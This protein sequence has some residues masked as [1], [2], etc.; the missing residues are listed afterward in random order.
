MKPKH[1]SRLS[2]PRDEILELQGEGLRPQSLAQHSYVIYEGRQQREESCKHMVDKDIP[3]PSQGLWLCFPP[4]HAHSL[5]MEW[6][7]QDTASE[8]TGFSGVAA[9]C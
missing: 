8:G 4:L 5:E 2:K 7:G 9:Q 3:L 6:G 1:R